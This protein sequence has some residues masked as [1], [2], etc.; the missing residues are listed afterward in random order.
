[1]LIFKKR[2]VV[3]CKGRINPPPTRVILSYL[4]TGQQRLCLRVNS[5]SLQFKMPILKHLETST[6][7]RDGGL[8][9]TRHT[10]SNEVCS[11]SFHP[12]FRSICFELLKKNNNNKK[13]RRDVFRG[14]HHYGRQTESGSQSD[15]F[16]L[17]SEWLGRPPGGSVPGS[18]SVHF[19]CCS[20][21]HKKVE[22]L[23]Q[24]DTIRPPG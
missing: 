24:T 22:P 21:R 19:M 4:F 23:Q 18:S 16:F 17:T 15:S 13:R 5:H 7:T 12:F 11:A 2:T 1:M 10:R 20:S 14:T 8:K 9:S 3:N 6:K